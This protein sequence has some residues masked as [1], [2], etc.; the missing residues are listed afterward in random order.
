MLTHSNAV[1]CFAGQ[2]LRVLFMVDVKGWARRGSPLSQINAARPA[3][4]VKRVALAATDPCSSFLLTASLP[5]S[6][7]C[8]CHCIAFCLF[9]EDR[10]HVVLPVA[11]RYWTGTFLGNLA[12]EA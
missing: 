11:A 12:H 9:V 10:L 1:M 6:R 8:N 7:I 3:A 2:G 5:N 4:T